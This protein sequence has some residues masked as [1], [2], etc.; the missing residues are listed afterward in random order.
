[1][2]ACLQLSA[3]TGVLPHIASLSPIALHTGAA[4]ACPSGYPAVAR[5]SVLVRG[6]CL[7]GLLVR[8]A[9]RYPLVEV[10]ASS[11]P[12]GATAP[13]PASSGGSSARQVFAQAQEWVEMRLPSPCQ[14][15]YIL[16]RRR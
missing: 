2:R 11:A 10:L 7:S 1:M 14:G 3:C 6:S 16:W 15:L 12:L 5:G 4:A 9:G 8:S 13:V